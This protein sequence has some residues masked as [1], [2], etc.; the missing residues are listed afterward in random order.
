MLSVAVPHVSPEP[1]RYL[2][3][4]QSLF[5]VLYH[6]KFIIKFNVEAF[7]SEKRMISLGRNK[8]INAK[9]TSLMGKKKKTYIHVVSL[10]SFLTM[11][12]TQVSHENADCQLWGHRNCQ[13]ET[14]TTPLLSWFTCVWD[15]AQRCGRSLQSVTARRVLEPRME[16][17]ASWNAQETSSPVGPAAASFKTYNSTSTWSDI[18]KAG[19]AM[20]RRKTRWTRN[21]LRE[22]QSNVVWVQKGDL[23]VFVIVFI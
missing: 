12:C 17:L 11:F 7:S 22:K 14:V 21:D 4:E 10:T 16:T 23:K 15:T 2:C 5:V 6:Y 3:Q 18:Q 13:R 8:S 9:N 1:R 19:R 20:Q